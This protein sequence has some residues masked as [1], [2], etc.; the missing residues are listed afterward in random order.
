MNK[1]SNHTFR[2]SV[3]DMRPHDLEDNTWSL[4]HH[5]TRDIILVGTLEQIQQKYD[6]LNAPKRQP[7]MA[8]FLIARILTSSGSVQTSPQILLLLL[9]PKG[10]RILRSVP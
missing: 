7:V 6:E 1:H 2:G 8:V 5:G 9:L 10:N 4:L 3:V